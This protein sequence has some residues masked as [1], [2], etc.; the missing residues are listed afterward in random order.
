MLLLCLCLAAPAVAGER[1][2]D[3]ADVPRP[4]L[5]GIAKRYPNARKLGFVKESEHGKTVYE[6]RLDA[7]GRKLEIDV[8]P[9]GKLLAEEEQ[10]AF[11]AIPDAVKKGLAAAPKVGKWSVQRAEKVS[12]PAGATPM[13][14][15]IVVKRGDE[16]AEVTLS[17]EGKVLATERGDDDDDR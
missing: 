3:E 9:D 7:D 13:K 1:K 11:A 10:V 12:D 6:V 8:A 4:V 17:E 14:Y 2:V 16:R 5:D 15:E